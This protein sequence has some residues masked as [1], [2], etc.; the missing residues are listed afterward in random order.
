MGAYNRMNGEPCCASPTLLR[1]I[2]REEWGFAGYIVSDC[3]AINDI[4]GGHKAVGTPAAAAALAVKAGCDL[5]CGCMYLSLLDAVEQSFIDEAMIDRAVK[6]L[7]AARFRLGMFDPPEQVPFAEIPYDINDSTEHRTLALRAA[8][9][10]IVLLKN[11][12]LLPLAKDLKSIAVIGPNA[13]DLVVLLGNYRG[14]PA[15]AVTPLEGIRRKVSAGTVVYTAQGCEIAAGMPPL[16]AV[17]AACLRPPADSYQLSAIGHQQPACGLMGAYFPGLTIPDSLPP[18]SFQLPPSFVRLDAIVDF[19]WR[20]ASPL[21]GYVTDPFCVRWTGA[22]IPPV[23]GRYLLGVRGSS[24]Y[25]L[26]LDGRE[27]LPYEGRNTRYSPGRSRSSWKR[28]G[29]TRLASTMSTMVAIRRCNCCGPF[30]ARTTSLRRCR[31]PGRPRSW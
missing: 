28:A 7:F 18:S 30:R 10:S 8:R 20:D 26:R 23:S 19:A 16:R 27:L 1:Q 6:R 22:L 13:D 29:H 15:H 21:G 14:T 5:E 12:G 17:P 4:Y 2:L 11:D 31:P 3:W 24:G 25:R 9:E